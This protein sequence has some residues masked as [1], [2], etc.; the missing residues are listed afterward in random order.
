MDI[1][2]QEK[3]SLGYVAHFGV[4]GMK[5]GVRKDKS[6]D[7]TESRAVR[8]ATR[9]NTS[10]F[11]SEFITR[12]YGNS[13]FDRKITKEQYDALSTKELTLRKGQTV[14]RVTK[15]SEDRLGDITFVSYKKVD[16]NTY[17]AV[18]PLVN[19]KNPLKLGGNKRYNNTYEATYKALSTLRSPSEKARV[20]A[21]IDLMDSREIRLRGNKVIT[22]RE[23]MRRNGFKKE[24]RTLDRQQLGLK[25]YRQFTEEQGS[26]RNKLA[27]AYFD[28]LRTQG[29]NS[30]VDDNDRYNLSETPLIL[31]NPNGT[32]KRMNVKRLSADEINQ[33]QRDL[34]VERR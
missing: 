7:S 15:S 4:K 16:Q 14:R 5:W 18:M 22:G 19:S 30:V 31:L 20:D 34:H 25:F 12:K 13:I 10:Q 33:A 26:K 6:Y 11:N 17:R 23:F 1:L 27:T 21:F 24:A 9:K 8:R 3:P 29:Y 32:L 2:G 28:K